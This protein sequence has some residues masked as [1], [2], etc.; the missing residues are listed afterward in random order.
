MTMRD[1]EKI[2]P[3]DHDGDFAAAD[4]TDDVYGIV[5]DGDI[6]V[7]IAPGADD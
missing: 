7:K 2:S 3:M 5:E 1:V 4:L 6:G